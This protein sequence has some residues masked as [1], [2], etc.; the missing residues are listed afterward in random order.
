M[1]D[2]HFSSVL[3]FGAT[4]EVGSIVALEAHALGA[5]VSI[6]LRDT[7]KQN[8]W[9]SPE[10]EHAAGLRRVSAD[11]TDPKAVT[12]AVH[13]TGSQA[14]FIYAV[15]SQDMLRGAISALRDAGIQYIVFL[16]TSQVRTAGAIKGDIRSIDPEHF[17][18][19]QHAQVEVALE[20]LNMP[21]AAIRA[22]FFASNPLRLYLDKS[23]DPK[24]VNLLAP[25]VPHDPLDPRDIGRAAA[26]VLVN[27]RLYQTDYHGPATKDIVDLSGPELLTQTEQWKIINRELATVGKPQVKVNHITVEQFLENLAKLHVPVIVAKSL[28]KSMVETRAL[29]AAEDHEKQW[30][31]VE[32]L[33]G[34]PATAFSDF[35]RREII[36]YFD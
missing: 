33:T 24:Q 23:S 9:I 21:H 2:P 16:S 1:T 15:R 25:E 22:G 20:E 35:V 31:N 5:H 36:K 32:L 12:R 14:A 11:L 8:E 13:E 3:V 34:R 4:G 26:A 27:P 29:Y 18:P 6:A 10:Q 17:I 28:A 30:G 19:Y 7:T